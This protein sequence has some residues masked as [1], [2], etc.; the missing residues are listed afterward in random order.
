MQ[1]VKAILKISYA[2]GRNS[3]RHFVV[4]TKSKNFRKIELIE[5]QRIEIALSETRKA[6]FS[7]SNFVNFGLKEIPP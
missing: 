7:K 4:P 5:R 1:N 3:V 6:K 2:Q